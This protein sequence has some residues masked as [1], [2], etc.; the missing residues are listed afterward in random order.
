MP[1]KILYIEDDTDIRELA[2]LVLEDDFDLIACASGEIALK[3]APDNQ[4]DLILVDV[5]MPGMD[6]PTTLEKLREFPHLQNTPVIFMTA[7]VTSLEQ[8]Q[9]RALNAGVIA[10]P[11]DPMSLAEQIN[12]YLATQSH[13]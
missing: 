13:G 1:A 3:H 10:K 2:I 11:F 4:I 12:D 6:G 7:K 5:M 9:Y 8:A